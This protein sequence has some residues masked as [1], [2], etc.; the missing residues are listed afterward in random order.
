MKLVIKIGSTCLDD[1]D[2]LR[3]FVKVAAQ[4]RNEGHRVTVVHGGTRIVLQSIQARGG[5]SGADLSTNG[6]EVRD[7]ALMMLGGRI[8]KMLVAIFGTIGTTAFGLCGTD[9]NIVRL[10]QRKAG[11]GNGTSMTEIVSVDPFWIE[12]MSSQGAVPILANVGIEADGHVQCLDADALAGACASAWSADALIIL[13]P[14]DC[15]RNSDGSV[16]RWLDAEK[17]HE[18]TRQSTLSENILSKLRVCRTALNQGVRRTR[19]LPLTH[20]ESLEQFY[21]ARIDGGTEVVMA[22][23][24]AATG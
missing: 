13:T 9:G 2:T 22:S 6:H 20:I 16:I 7:A 17:I 14:A 5:T 4:L 18:L 15:P 8:N 19:I 1:A 12:N 3:K 21:F 23:R 24:K 10:R 11:D